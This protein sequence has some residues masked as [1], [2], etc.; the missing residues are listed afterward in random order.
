MLEMIPRACQGA[1][2]TSRAA[3]GLALLFVVI[4]SRK[5]HQRPQHGLLYGL[6][7]AGSGVSLLR[8]I[9]FGSAPSLAGKSYRHSN[10]ATWP[11]RLQKLEGQ[12]QTCGRAGNAQGRPLRQASKAMFT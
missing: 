12:R 5:L 1:A 7:D 11:V 2:V 4:W 10:W 8:V 9:T 3:P 6:R